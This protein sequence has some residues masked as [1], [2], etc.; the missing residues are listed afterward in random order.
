MSRKIIG[1]TVGSPLPKPDLRQTD[2]AK[3]DYVK[4]KEVLNGKLDANKLPEAINDALAQAKASGEFDGK[5]GVS[6]SHSWN[7]T[8]LTITSASGTS[9]ANLK[10]DP[11]DVASFDTDESL[12]LENGVLKVNTTSVVAQNS[13]LPVTSAAVYALVGDIESALAAI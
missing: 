1:V 9:S 11:G 5:D 4:G 2:P 10:G 7:G 12:T 8:T 3:G 13:T 6:V